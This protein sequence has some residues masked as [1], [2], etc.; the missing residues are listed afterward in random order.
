MDTDVTEIEFKVGDVLYHYGYA[1]RTK[2]RWIGI[3]VAKRHGYEAISL[4]LDITTGE[5]SMHKRFI[6]PDRTAWKKL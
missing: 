5:V 4:V 6:A 3:I 2:I 1:D